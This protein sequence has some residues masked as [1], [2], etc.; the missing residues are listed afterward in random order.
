MNN[1]I[2]QVLKEYRKMNRL[3]VSDVCARLETEYGLR[4]A[5]KT[6]YGWESNQAHPTA[7]TFII[8]CEIYGISRVSSMYEKTSPEEELVLSDEEKELVCNY[9][10]FTTFQSA[11]RYLLHV[12]PRKHAA[13]NHPQV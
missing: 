1:K 12:S 3:S 7:D 6:V 11:V 9:R 13:G 10:R 5:P 2:G 4:I 8:M